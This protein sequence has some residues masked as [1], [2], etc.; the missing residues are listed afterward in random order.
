M[1]KIVKTDKDYIDFTNE[2]LPESISVHRAFENITILN[3]KSKNPFKI[4]SKPSQLGVYIYAYSRK[5][6][7]N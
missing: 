6:M 2:C 3:G 7:Y 1:T 5:L 4:T